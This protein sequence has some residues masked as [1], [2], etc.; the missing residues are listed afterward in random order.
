[1]PGSTGK[2][3]LGRG[4]KTLTWIE[5][6]DLLDA[7]LAS[8]NDVA[9]GFDMELLEAIVDAEAEAAGDAD[10]AMRAISGA[11]T[12]AMA[13]GVGRMQTDEGDARTRA[14]N[15]GADEEGSG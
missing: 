10:F 7:V 4:S 1:M 15:D 3:L 14:R 8:R 5:R 12:T 6:K 11:V 9:P 2:G 13:R